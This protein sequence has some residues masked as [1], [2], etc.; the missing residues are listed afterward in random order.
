MSQVYIIKN[1]GIWIMDELL[2]FSEKVTFKIIFLRRP[3]TFFEDKIDILLKRGIKIY[4]LD[5]WNISLKKLS[6]CLIF[7]L[8]HLS[9]FRNKHS[10][11]YGIKSLFYFLKL[12]LGI[13]NDSNKIHSQFA[14]QASIVAL[15]L[16]EFNKSQTSYT[17][18][19]HAYDIYVK[20]HWFNILSKYADKVFSIS[21]YNIGYILKHYTIDSKK[22]IYSPLGV[23]RPSDIP[24][25]FN[26]QIVK[27]G[28]LSYFVGMKG[29]DYLLP[30]VKYLI[31]NN[32]MSLILEMA[33]DGPMK[34]KMVKFVEENSLKENIIFPGL[35]KNERKEEFFRSLDV[36][37]LPSIS[38]GIETDGLPVVLM[39]A[40]SYG[41]PI[42]STKVTGIPEICIDNFNGY[43][44]E[45][46]SIETL[47]S[48]IVKF[49]D[50]KEK[51]SEFSMNSLEIA[52]KY[53][54]VTNSKHKLEILEW[55]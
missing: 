37:I 51:W 26:T 48:A 1:A 16:K 25:S 54:L 35:V 52:K 38:R 13:V 47:V 55:S 49:C 34:N 18:T 27:I 46:E 21:N 7:V 42:I 23:F 11:V 3:G 12:D 44:I 45:P 33:G 32:K 19:C 22:L 6:F 10:F 17:F 36:F 9:C 43:L 39:E 24:K 8:R 53:D 20:N 15:L 4:Y 5:S 41:V 50:N 28:F 14:T 40:V 31:D 29:I 2:A 30:A